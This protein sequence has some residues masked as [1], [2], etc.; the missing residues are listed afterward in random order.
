[1]SAIDRRRLIGGILCGAVAATG[2]ALTSGTTDAMPIDARITGSLDDLIVKAQVVVVNPRRPPP[3]RR[4][5][6]RCWWHRGRRVC[7][8]R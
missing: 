4:R 8:W 3:R 5:R 7:G 1:M 2:L 6:W